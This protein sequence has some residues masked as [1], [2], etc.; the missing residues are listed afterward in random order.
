MCVCVCVC[1]CVCTYIHV[2]MCVVSHRLLALATS[3]I[4]NNIFK[5]ASHLFHLLRYNTTITTTTTTTTTATTTNNNKQH[6]FN[7]LGWKMK[8]METQIEETLEDNTIVLF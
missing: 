5:V 6:I 4:N 1:V 7:N 2:C 3:D 8:P